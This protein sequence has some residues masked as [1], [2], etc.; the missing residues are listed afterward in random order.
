MSKKLFPGKNGK[1]VF[2]KT[3]HYIYRK[4]S[5]S[6]VDSVCHQRVVSMRTSIT[7]IVEI[8]IPIK[9]F[10]LIFSLFRN[11][12]IGNENKGLDIQITDKKAAPAT[13]VASK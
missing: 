10:K 11:Q 7:P 2:I 13:L 6:F 9:P 4:C 12:E 5:R 3:D 1:N 8:I